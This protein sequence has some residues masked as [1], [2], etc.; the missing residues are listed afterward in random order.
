MTP[1]KLI[2]CDGADRVGKTTLI[3]EIQSH[4]G[5]EKCDTVH[6]SEP[7]N[8][9]NDPYD[10]NREKIGEWVASGKEWFFFDRSYPCSMVYEERRRGNAGHLAHVVEIEVELADCSDEFQVVH[11]CVEKPWRWSAKHHLIEVRQ[12]FPEA[13][14]WFVR[15]QMISRMREHKEFYEKMYD[16]Y[17]NI[18]M[19]PIA[20]FYEWETIEDLFKKINNCLSN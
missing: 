1:R 15:D 14:P 5:K 16:F 6:L 8:N 19:F 17:E 4:L 12:L 7:A 10:I 2:I 18:T 3:A 9:Q 11:V 20:Y 13:A